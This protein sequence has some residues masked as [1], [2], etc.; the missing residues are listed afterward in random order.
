MDNSNYR[1]YYS[2]LQEESDYQLCFSIG[3]P[4]L[5]QSTKKHQNCAGDDACRSLPIHESSNPSNYLPIIMINSRNGEYYSVFQGEFD[6]QL[7]FSIVILLL[8]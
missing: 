5:W 1:V 7:C 2:V 8:W 3:V 4:V 6:Y